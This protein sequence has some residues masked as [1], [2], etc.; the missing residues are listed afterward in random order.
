MLFTHMDG[1]R[2]HPLPPCIQVDL[3]DRDLVII[4]INCNNVHWTL[5]LINVRWRRFEYY[6]SMFGSDRGRLRVLRRYLEDEHK[7]RGGGGE[8]RSGLGLGSRLRGL[9]SRSRGSGSGSGLGGSREPKARC[10]GACPTIPLSLLTPFFQDKKGAP[11]DLSEWTDVRHLPG[12]LP[13]QTNGYDCGVF[14]CR[15]AEYLTR[16]ARLDFKQVQPEKGGGR[17]IHQGRGGAWIA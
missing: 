7:V 3:F 1:T 10:G 6:D 9:G 16:G 11:I 5:A 14:M 13:E 12:S 2:T 17:K 15:T 8:S 4:P